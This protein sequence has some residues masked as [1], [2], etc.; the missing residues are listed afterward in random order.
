VIKFVL[1]TRERG[2]L[3]N[4]NLERGVHAFVDSDYAG[5]SDNSR[6][7]TGYIIYFRGVAIAWKSK[8]QHCVT[9]SSS[10]AEC[11]AISEVSIELKSLKRTHESLCR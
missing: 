2:I 4:P 7:S 6:S 9:L 3:V 11:Y 5:D 8:Q 1:I 10:E